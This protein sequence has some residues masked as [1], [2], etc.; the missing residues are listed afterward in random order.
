MLCIISKNKTVYKCPFLKSK[1]ADFPNKSHNFHFEEPQFKI[2]GLIIV[3]GSFASG[4]PKKTI[5]FK[6]H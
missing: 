6:S 4:H 2:L 5:P 3:Y 1:C